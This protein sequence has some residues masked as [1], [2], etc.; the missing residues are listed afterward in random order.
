LGK[1][2]TFIFTFRAARQ[3]PKSTTASSRRSSLSSRRSSVSSRRLQI[4]RRRPTTLIVDDNEEVREYFL[5][6]AGRL[7]L[8][9]AAASGANE[10]LALIGANGPYDIYFVD[11]RMPG[12]DGIALAKRLKDIPDRDSKIVLISGAEWNTIADEATAAGV[13]KFLP[14][15]LFPAALVDCISECLG[16]SSDAPTA[17]T[18]PSALDDC[19]KGRRL[20]LVEDVEI[21]REIV[22]TL[23]EATGIEIDSAVNGAE[24]V[25]KFTAAPEK[26]DIVF[27]DIEMPVM[28]GYEAVKHIRGAAYPV[29][30]TMP[31]IAMTAN[32]FREDIDK[33]LAAGMN[34]HIGKPLDFDMVIAKLQTY[35]A[36]KA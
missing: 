32:V 26:Y 24:A 13:D 3:T 2:A 29:A 14:K 5:E 25:E 10:A 28:N 30:K 9:C 34:G 35:L 31:I 15:P 33:C 6:V 23:L 12:L 27:M 19:F 7:G 16:T 20:L 4:L 17:I 18:E 22:E 1:G 8:Q 11:W 21:N 36:K